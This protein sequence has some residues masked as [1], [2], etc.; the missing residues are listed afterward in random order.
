MQR[1]TTQLVKT[2]VDFR[3]G[4][5]RQQLKLQMRDGALRTAFGK[6]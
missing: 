6:A 2:C 1:I 3:L 5:Q 4:G